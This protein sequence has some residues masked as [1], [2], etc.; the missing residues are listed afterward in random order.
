MIQ[1]VKIIGIRFN[2]STG[3]LGNGYD[4]TKPELS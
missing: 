1:K 2:W 3:G 4:W